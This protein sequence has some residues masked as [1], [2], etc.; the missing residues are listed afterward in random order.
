M[1]STYA[2]GAVLPGTNHHPHHAS[3]HISVGGS[4]LDRPRGQSSP[5]TDLRS[6]SGESRGRAWSSERI[7]GI[8]TQKTFVL[9]PAIRKVWLESAETCQ[10]RSAEEVSL[11]AGLCL[12]S[13]LGN[14]LRRNNLLFDCGPSRTSR[15][16]RRPSLLGS[17]RS[18]STGPTRMA[19]TGF[20]SAVDHGGSRRWHFRIHRGSMGKT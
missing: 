4:S 20:L 2:A 1:K 6:V 14:F 7:C 12:V 9:R 11:P 13:R 15:G 19:G 5:R 3:H 17:S 16:T 10:D 8:V 18:R